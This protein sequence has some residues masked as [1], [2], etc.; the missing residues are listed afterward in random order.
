MVGRRDFQETTRLIHVYVGE[1]T[2]VVNVS[3]L[4][5]EKILPVMNTT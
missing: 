2:S 1:S 5:E 3:N 4:N